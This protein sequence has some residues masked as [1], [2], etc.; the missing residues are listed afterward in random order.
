MR[1]AFLA[2]VLAVAPRIAAA[3]PGVHVYEDPDDPSI[4]EGETVIDG[5]PASVFRTMLDYNKWTQIFPD[6]AKVEVKQRHGDE[7]M[8]T[9]I[10]PDGH[11][12]NLHFKNQPAARMVFFEDT[13]GRAQ[14]WA[15]IVFV[16]GKAAGTTRVHTR[17]YAD[18]HGLAKL[19]ANG[20]D[21]RK[22]REDKIERDLVH[23]RGYFRRR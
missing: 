3:S 23:I 4:T 7:A 15:E 18:V 14:V 9:L 19:F 12:D 1:I 10:A 8:V 16:P 20:G 11:R 21:I 17:L 6:V 13:G 2:V 5:D 22:L